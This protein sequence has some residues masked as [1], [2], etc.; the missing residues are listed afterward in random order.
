MR[1]CNPRWMRECRSVWQR[2]EFW[3]QQKVPTVW[4]PCGLRA[5]RLD[6]WVRDDGARCDCNRRLDGGQVCGQVWSV[7][8]VQ[9]ASKVRGGPDLC[10]SISL[11]LVF[12]KPLKEL[13]RA[14]ECP[15]IANPLYMRSGERMPI[16][17][18]NVPDSVRFHRR[19]PLRSGCQAQRPGPHPLPAELGHLLQGQRRCVR[20]SS[21]AESDLLLCLHDATRWTRAMHE[22]V[23]CTVATLRAS[24]R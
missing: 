20:R 4:Q 13:F 22:A 24:R 10:D 18:R 5:N 3:M 2:L 23:A 21:R 7:G 8:C 14:P 11:W 16:S 1:T 19:R 6:E 15:K 17:D 9:G 12:F